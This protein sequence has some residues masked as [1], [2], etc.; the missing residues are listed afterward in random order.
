[1][2]SEFDPL[3]LQ[4]VSRRSEGSPVDWQ[5]DGLL[6]LASPLRK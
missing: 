1:M 3:K 6:V 4:L 2:V 5:K